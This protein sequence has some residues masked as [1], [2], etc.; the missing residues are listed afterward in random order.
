MK[1]WRRYSQK[2]TELWQRRITKTKLVLE[3]SILSALVHP[4]RSHVNQ[5]QETLIMLPQRLVIPVSRKYQAITNIAFYLERNDVKGFDFMDG[6]MTLD[7]PFILLDT[8]LR[9]RQKWLELEREYI[10][11]GGNVCSTDDDFWEAAT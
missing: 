7:I 2:L 1:K 6:G 9:E 3:V 5:S 11:V 4:P 8:Q 10:A